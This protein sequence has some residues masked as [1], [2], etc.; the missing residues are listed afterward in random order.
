MFHDLKH[1]RAI[2]AIK[3]RRQAALGITQARL[4]LLSFALSLQP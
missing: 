3:L 4:V 1:A 2:F